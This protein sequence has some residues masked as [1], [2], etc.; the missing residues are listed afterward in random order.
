MKCRH[1]GHEN[2][3]DAKYCDIFRAPLAL[4]EIA[5]LNPVSFVSEMEE[6]N[7]E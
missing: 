2:R 7:D 3:D 1:C 4:A 6:Q 5:M